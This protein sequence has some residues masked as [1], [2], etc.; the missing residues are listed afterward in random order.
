M[1]LMLFSRNGL[2]D[3]VAQRQGNS[4]KPPQIN[5]TR[6]YPQLSHVSCN[7]TELAIRRATRGVRDVKVGRKVDIVGTHYV[8]Y[9]ARAHA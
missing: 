3:G 2:V 8:W 6:W 1:H 7:G 4:M 9:A 5:K